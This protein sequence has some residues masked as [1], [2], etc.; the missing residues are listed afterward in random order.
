M[1][2]WLI[3]LIGAAAGACVMYVQD[4]S[5]IATLQQ[6]IQELNA[7]KAAAAPVPS[8][9]SDAGI[10]SSIRTLDGH[11][12]TNCRVIKQDSTGITFSHSEGIAQIPFYNMPPDL[13]KQFG[14]SIEKTAAQIE[15]ESRY[16]DQQAAA[17]QTSA[18]TTP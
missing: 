13:Q 8:S 4:A 15:A 3:L 10:I 14:Y 5:Q 1:K 7:A 6:Q 12:Y 2:Y 11:L 9:T 16:N 17:L 18:G